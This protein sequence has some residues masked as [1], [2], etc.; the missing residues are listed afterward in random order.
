[1]VKKLNMLPHDFL[2]GIKCFHEL[3]LYINSYKRDRDALDSIRNN[4]VKYEIPAN[5]IVKDYGNLLFEDTVKL[6]VENSDHF[7]DGYYVMCFDFRILLFKTTDLKKR[8]SLSLFFV[9]MS[10]FF[11]YYK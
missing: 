5:D 7:E 10:I 8:K 6:K 3:D 2:N 11:N 1:M 9:F 4:H